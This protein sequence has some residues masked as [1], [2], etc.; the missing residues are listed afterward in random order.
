MLEVLFWVDVSQ[1]GI[2]ANF[3]RLFSAKEIVDCYE[4]IQQPI[5]TV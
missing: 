5:V 2:F 3:I 4:K 1:Q